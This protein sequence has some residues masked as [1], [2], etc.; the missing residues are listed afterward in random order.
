V[1]GTIGLAL[2]VV[3]AGLL[4]RIIEN[5]CGVFVALLAVMLTVMLP[6]IPALILAELSSV[7][8]ML[9]PERVPHESG[10]PDVVTALACTAK[11]VVVGSP[12]SGHADDDD[13]TSFVPSNVRTVLL[14]A[15]PFHV[16]RLF[17]VLCVRCQP[18]PLLSAA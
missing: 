14:F 9:P 12:V 18:L 1:N 17:A 6:P 10:W 11:I 2:E 7:M 4:G 16:G 3:D 5:S 15:E 8:L 13:S